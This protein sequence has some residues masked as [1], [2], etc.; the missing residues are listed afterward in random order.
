MTKVAV[1]ANEG[2][3]VLGTAGNE[4]VV[5]TDSSIKTGGGAVRVDGNLTIKSGLL[6]VQGDWTGT[7]DIKVNEVVEYSFPPVF[8]YLDAA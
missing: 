3:L 5:D 1:Q 4:I 8:R 7:G 2:T 6:T